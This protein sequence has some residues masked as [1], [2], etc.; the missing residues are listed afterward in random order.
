MIT[1]DPWLDGALA[2]LGWT[3]LLVGGPML[4]AAAWPLWDDSEWARRFR[5]NR[6]LREQRRA[7]VWARREREAEM[8]ATLRAGRWS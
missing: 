2:E 8:R 1:V 4:L 5:R 6:A 7:A 3:L